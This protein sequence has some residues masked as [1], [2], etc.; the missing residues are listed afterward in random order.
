MEARFQET[1]DAFEQV[2]QMA[3]KSKSD[4]EKIKKLRYSMS[5][6]AFTLT[7]SLVCIHTDTFPGVHSC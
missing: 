4:F 1:A 2:R 7:L 3:K 5:H 6:C